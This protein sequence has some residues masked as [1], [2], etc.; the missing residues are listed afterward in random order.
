M[1]FS[2]SNDFNVASPLFLII[3]FLAGSVTINVSVLLAKLKSFPLSSATVVG[4]T[5]IVAL[6]LFI[7]LIFI[8]TVLSST[9]AVPD[10]TVATLEFDE[11]IVNPPISSFPFM[12]KFTLFPLLILVADKDIR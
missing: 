12:Y 9:Q 3:G 10:S 8:V 6:P 5:V 4:V 1:T 2:I 11:E 7:A